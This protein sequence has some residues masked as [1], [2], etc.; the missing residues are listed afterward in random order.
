MRV[1]A[2]DYYSQDALNEQRP[3]DLWRNVPTFGLMPGTS[4]TGIIVTPACD[5]DNC[6][7]ETLSY[8]PVI[9]VATYLCS[10]AM[11]RRAKQELTNII[12]TQALARHLPPLLS[13]DTLT[14]R[15]N[16]AN[17]IQVL[18]GTD[19]NRLGAEKTERANAGVVLLNDIAAGRVREPRQLFKLLFAKGF[20]KLV[21]DIVRNNR[22]DTHFLP[23]DGQPEAYSAILEHSVILLRYPLTVP[24]E[25]MDGIDY[26]AG[27]DWKARYVG[28]AY[29]RKSLT[30][31]GDDP[32]IKM[33]RVR[34]P[35]MKIIITRYTGMFARLGSPDFSPQWCHNFA[36]RLR[37]DLDV[38]CNDGRN[39]HMDPKP[40]GHNGATGGANT[41]CRNTISTA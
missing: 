3:G 18:I 4:C 2:Y 40:A 31:F 16:E 21:E 26:S 6:K 19:K 5:L 24:I 34:E 22:P 32:P 12:G 28:T 35:Y 37:I 36:P 23:K 39:C 27:T 17:Q 15:E 10:P 33:G 14:M 41:G 13:D 7:T 1:T 11:A 29:L 9:P 20:K 25:L 8:L 30:M 38:F